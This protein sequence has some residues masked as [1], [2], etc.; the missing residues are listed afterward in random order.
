MLLVQTLSGGN[1][2][3]SRETPKY[4]RSPSKSSSSFS[5]RLCHLATSCPFP[6]SATCHIR[7][8]FR[9]ARAHI[10]DGHDLSRSLSQALLRPRRP[11]TYTR[12]RFNCQCKHAR[13][14]IT[15]TADKTRSDSTTCKRAHAI[16]NTASSQIGTHSARL[17]APHVHARTCKQK[18]DKRR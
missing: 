1:P 17:H 6:E 9:V 8:G 2:Q 18:K 7:T 3:S 12:T 13:A 11:A 16:G 14:S 5:N 4:L 10:N 15:P